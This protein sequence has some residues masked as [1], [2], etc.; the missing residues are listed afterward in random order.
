MIDVI[1]F[2]DDYRDDIFINTANIH[3]VQFGTVKRNSEEVPNVK[4]FIGTMP[5]VSTDKDTIK[6]VRKIMRDVF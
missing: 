1:L 6:L 2:K 3:T 4:L 5:A